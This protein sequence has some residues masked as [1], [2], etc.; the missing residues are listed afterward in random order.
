M[1]EFKIRNKDTGMLVTVRGDTPPPPE[2]L[3][4]IFSQAQKGAQKK[5]SDGSYKLASDNIRELSK[6]E[7]RVKIKS[8]SAQALGI[9][10]DDVDIDTG[11]GLWDRTKLAFQPTEADKMKQLED[12]YGAENVA[13]LDV[14]GTGKMFYRDPKTSKMTMVDEQGTSLADFT[15]DIAGDVLPIAG[16]IGA[17]VATGGASIPLT[18]LAAA[19]GGL[20]TGIAQDVGVR[21]ASGEDIR[22]GEIAKRQA[23]TNAIGIPIDMVTGVGG[24]MLSKTIGKRAADQGAQ[25]LTSGID[26]LISRYDKDAAVKLTPAQEA[27]T[28][29][30]LKQSIRAGMDPSGPEARAYEIQRDEIGKLTRAIRGEEVLDEPIE[31]VMQNVASRQMKLIDAYEARIKKMDAAKIDAEALAKKQTTKQK[32]TIKKKLTAERDLELKAMRKQAEDGISKL[33]KGKQRLTSTLGDDVR[34]EQENAFRSVKQESDDLYEEAYRRLDTPQ[35]NT[36][37]P[38]IQRVLDRIDDAALDEAAPELAAIKRLRARLADTTKPQELTFR[39]LDRYLREITDKINYKKKF[40]VGESQYQLQQIGKRLEGLRNTAMGAP[41]KLG[42]RGAGAPAK[43]AYMKAKANYRSKVL[44]YFDGDR[45]ANLSRIIGDSAEAVG[46]RGE[47]VLARTFATRGAVKD[48]LKSGVNRNTLKEAYLERVTREAGDGEIKVDENILAEL[49]STTR[50]GQAKVMA[51]IRAINK[52]IRSGKGDAKVTSAEVKSILDEFDPPARA[53]KLRALDEKKAT[54]KKLAE[55][56]QSALSK[57]IKGELPTPE[58]IHHFVGDIAK[59]RPSQI[60]KLKDRLPSDRARESLRRSGIDRLMEDAGELSAKAQRTGK[61][62]GREALWEP[63]KM[64]DILNNST[65]RAQWEALVGKET[66]RDMENLNRWLLSSAEIRETTQEGIGRFV[67]S[68]GASGPPNVL[69]VSPQLPRWIGR[70]MLGVIHTSPLTRGIM[71][72]SLKDGKVD[73]ELFERLFY[74]AMGTQRGLDAITDEMAK[75]PT[76]SAWMTESVKGGEG[77]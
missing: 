74:T 63:D 58:D 33:T 10:E 43:A 16:A 61:E 9:S 14:G 36:P 71:R 54:E 44:P 62:T 39:E 5:L 4:Q 29:A 7:R 41:A 57:I 59:L 64:A 19:G 40:N 13:M 60:L 37:I 12:T 46:A 30:S 66:V 15:A 6:D 25:K 32:E 26:D 45:A 3:P 72:R 68:T 22:F 42:A 23:I 76:F 20:A 53:K 8:L 49:Y 70:K 55:A 34:T 11:M 75:D 47:N 31:D 56:R 65:K 17:A 73:Q 2:A 77:Q 18:A 51:D 69:F 48:A 50:G 21:A 67:T 35:A 24:R 38:S 28:D 52:A 1:E 27:S